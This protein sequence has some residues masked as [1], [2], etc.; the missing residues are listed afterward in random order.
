MTLPYRRYRLARLLVLTAM[1]GGALTA[2]GDDENPSTSGEVAR[3]SPTATT[4]AEDP[5]GNT[6]DAT[7]EP[8]DA[9]IEIAMKDI[10]FKPAYVTVRVGQ[11]LVFI[12]ED[13]VAHK[14]ESDEGQPFTSKSLG[15]GE[16][17]RYRIKNE[18]GLRNMNFICTIHPAQ[19]EGGGVVVK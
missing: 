12:N 8:A 10:A 13:D 9:S 1:A 2:C 19:M 5:A 17:Y 16:K 18:A 3:T 15:K 14:L 7:S 4:E 6:Y 11:T